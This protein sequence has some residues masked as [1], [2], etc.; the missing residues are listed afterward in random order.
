MN[1]WFWI[2]LN[3]SSRTTHIGRWAPL[4]R[5]K[6][7][8]EEQL[9]TMSPNIQRNFCSTYLPSNLNLEILMGLHKRVFST[10]LKIKIKNTNKSLL[11]DTY[12]SFSSN[13]PYLYILRFLGFPFCL[14][15]V[16]FLI[17]ETKLWE[18]CFFWLNFSF[19]SK[20]HV[21]TRKPSVC[22]NSKNP[23]LS[24]SK[25]SRK[26]F[27][28]T[29]SKQSKFFELIRKTANVTVNPKLGKQK[30][31]SIDSTELN[32]NHLNLLVIPSGGRNLIILT[33]EIMLKVPTRLQR[34]QE[35]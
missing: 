33:A 35:M 6:R 20:K 23:Y 8:L 24:T 28:A 5:L 17:S 4:V 9:L 19:L 30:P 3:R 21:K 22:G 7:T 31:V 1:T 14:V 15:M 27:S 16:I 18:I 10:K 25:N 34:E 29:H 2:L 12:I 11:H 13:Y 26:E 32:H